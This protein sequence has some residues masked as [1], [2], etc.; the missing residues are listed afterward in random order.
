MTKLTQFKLKQGAT[1]FQGIASPQ[2]LGLLGGQLQKF[3]P[4]LDDLLTP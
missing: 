4:N 2:G 3:V 1:F